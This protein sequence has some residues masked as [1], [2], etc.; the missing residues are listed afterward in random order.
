[1]H[2]FP[3]NRQFYFPR[4]SQNPHVVVVKPVKYTAKQAL[5]ND[6]YETIIN[7][8]EVSRSMRR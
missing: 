8:E 3:V 5:I 4:H 2:L 6:G 1:M 7:N